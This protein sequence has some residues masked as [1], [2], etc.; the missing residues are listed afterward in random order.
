MMIQNSLE[1]LSES[2]Y[3]T[4]VFAFIQTATI[5]LLMIGMT[6]DTSAQ[7]GDGKLGLGGQI[8]DPSGVSARWVRSGTFDLDFLAAWDLDNFFYLNVHGLHGRPVESGSNVALFYGP[9][10]FVGLRDRPRQK[11]DDIVLGV[12]AAVGLSLFLDQL[13]LYV[14]LTPRLSIIPDTNGDVGG[15]IGPRYY[16]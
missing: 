12:S 10:V 8:G 5:A 3:S 13:E 11:G 4:T 9:G 1:C 6:P 16:F 15:G 14:R 7:V 2:R